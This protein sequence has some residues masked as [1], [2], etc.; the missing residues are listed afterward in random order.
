MYVPQNTPFFY[1]WGTMVG[2][3]LLALKNIRDN[4]T[5]WFLRGRK[6]EIQKRKILLLSLILDTLTAH[7]GH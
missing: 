7:R 5:G 2:L 1:D 3:L 4:E 6:M